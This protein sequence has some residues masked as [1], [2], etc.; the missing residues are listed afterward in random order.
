MITTAEEYQKYLWQ[1]QDTNH[2]VSAILLPSN[3][4]V[5]EIDLN[6]R[7]IKAPE[8]LSV[9]QDHAAETI[10]F[11]VDRFYDN[12]DLSTTTCVIQ[13]TNALGENYY[14]AVPF[15]DITTFATTVSNQFTRVVIDERQYKTGEFYVQNEQYD[16]IPATG[17]FDSTKDYF[18]KVVP[19]LNKK[20]VS[21]KLTLEKYN[22]NSFY[23]IDTDSTSIT[24]GKYV[25]DTSDTFNPQR[26]YFAQIDRRYIPIA[27]SSI[28]Y[29]INQYYIVNAYGNMELSNRPYS[30]KET[31]FIFVD[32]QKMIFPWI[33]GKDVTKQAGDI[34]FQIRFYQLVSQQNENGDYDYSYAYNLNTR[35][36]KSKV[37]N[38]Y[39]D[40]ITQTEEQY[41]TPGSLAEL[42]AR[43]A[44]VEREGEIFWI[45]A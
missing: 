2:P 16:Y 20:Y 15:Y 3:E 6:S 31:Y 32:T 14:S 39:P 37:L 41:F 18:L 33:I 22:P 4:N 35:P 27:V 23:Y 21:V 5:Y 38:G 36:A 24:H 17:Q 44:A 13:Y 1:L 34:T 30:D 8:Y 9:T 28:E 29:Q 19:N 12:M 45:E 10:Y 42:E 25:L 40:V 11:L 7:I 26:N 43:I